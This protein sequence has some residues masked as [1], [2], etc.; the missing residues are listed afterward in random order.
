MHCRFL[1]IGETLS[2]NTRRP[3]RG[4]SSRTSGMTF[5]SVVRFYKACFERGGL[6]PG[7]VGEQGVKREIN[8]LL[9]RVQGLKNAAAHSDCLL[10]GLANHASREPSTKRI[11]RALVDVCGMSER[12]VSDV[13]S[14]RV[15]M[16]LAAVLVCFDRLVSER[17]TR[18]SAASLL[19]AT[20]ERFLLYSDW[21]SKNQ[22]V[23]AF[24]VFIDEL[25][26][27]AAGKYGFEQVLAS[28]EFNHKQSG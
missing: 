6:I 27:C 22:D 20:R 21:F 25:F 10:N 4:S 17:E 14:V 7:A 15:A 1:K 18:S 24:L 16:D 5:G 26:L 19:M 23:R 8:P 13:A 2:R 12:V 3:A 11:R 9:R 28:G